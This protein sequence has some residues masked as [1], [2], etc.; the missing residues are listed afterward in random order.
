MEGNEINKPLPVLLLSWFAGASSSST[1]T[2]GKGVFTK[3]HA[4]REVSQKQVRGVRFYS[5]KG[6]LWQAS[7]SKG[8]LYNIF[9]G[10]NVKYI[11]EL[12]YA[13]LQFSV[14]IILSAIFYTEAIPL[15]HRGSLF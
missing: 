5:Q 9:R 1:P 7:L 14:K 11:S 6:L 13:P 12:H 2:A 15:N 4:S 10:T 3:C 8:C